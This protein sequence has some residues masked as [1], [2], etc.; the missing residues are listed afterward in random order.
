VNRNQQKTLFKQIHLIKKRE[1][2]AV[3]SIDPTT[4]SSFHLTLD[5]L[6]VIKLGSSEPEFNLGLT[7][8]YNI[9]QEKLIENTFFFFLVLEIEPVAFAC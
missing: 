6:K 7:I 1:R 3:I 2:N 5:M 4:N 8:K 9:Q